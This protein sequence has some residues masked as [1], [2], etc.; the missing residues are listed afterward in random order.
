MTAKGDVILHFAAVSTACL[1][2]E[3]DR[4]RDR[5]DGRIALVD[6]GNQ[7]RDTLVQGGAGALRLLN[8]MCV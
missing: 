4:R 3:I 2:S 8:L 7:L 6:A 1:S 5:L